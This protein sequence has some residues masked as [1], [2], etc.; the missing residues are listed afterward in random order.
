[1]LVTQVWEKLQ[2]GVA[3]ATRMKQ[4]LNII[5][6]L[7][8]YSQNPVGP[9]FWQ[10]SISQH[11]YEFGVDREAISLPALSFVKSLCSLLFISAVLTPIQHVVISTLDY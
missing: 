7:L 3:G 4:V 11:V 1:M 2:I 10:V 9:R 6:Y 8:I 5:P